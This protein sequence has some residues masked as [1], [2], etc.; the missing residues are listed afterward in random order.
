[1]IAF[2]RRIS[3][4]RLLTLCASLVAIGG[5]GTAIAI[6]ATSGGPVPQPKD[7]PVAIHDALTAPK[8][9]GVTARI[10]FTNHLINNSDVRGGSPLLSGA[11]G[12]LWASSDGHVRLELQADASSEGGGS[13]DSQI[14]SDGH[15]VTAYDSGSNTVYKAD[16][17]AD[18][19]DSTDASQDQ[20]PS[21]A[22]IQQKLNDLME[23]ATVSGAQPSDV[24]GQPAYTVRIEPK[25]DGGLVGGAELAWDAV[26]GTPLRAAVYAKGDSSPVLELT[27]TDISYGPVD[28]SVFDVSP[29]PD[30]KVTD[31]TPKSGT[32]GTEGSGQQDRAPVTGL[33]QVQAAVSFPIAAPDSLAGL[34]R[35]EVRL[36]HSGDH[37]AALVTYG[38]GLGGIAV[39]E[40]PA[41]AQS[42]SNSSGDNGQV[43]LPTVTINGVQ[44]H[45]LDTPL[46][47]LIDFQ[48]TGVGYTVIGSVVPATALA[49]AQGL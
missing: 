6:A 47:T 22:E 37:P 25:Q 27:V 45:E 43:S 3:T 21:I 23:H 15:S 30:A 26:H 38:E 18:R 19:K 17:P 48:R 36:I 31:L 49:A 39:I 9:E 46:G 29:P 14:V 11:S 42:N 10:H 40:H 16:L 1:V 20:P 12:R 35:N 41:D 28:S 4:R 7:L 5:G 2:L 33:Q 44:G 24:A 13:S 8:V 32:G 34:P